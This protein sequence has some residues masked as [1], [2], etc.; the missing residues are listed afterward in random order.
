MSINTT[1]KTNKKE[2]QKL[3]HCSGQQRPV[4]GL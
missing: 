1:G 2:K 3:K 4:N